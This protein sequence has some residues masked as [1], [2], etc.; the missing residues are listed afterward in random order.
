MDGLKQMLW[1]IFC[2]SVRPSTL[3]HHRQQG[4]CCCF[5]EVRNSWMT[6]SSYETKLCKMTSHF[7]LLTRKYF[8]KFFFRVTNSTL[9]NIKL[10]FELLTLSINF[11]FFTFELLNRSWK[12]KS[13]TLS[14]QLE[15]K[16]WKVTLQVTNSKSRN[17]KIHFELLTQRLNFFCF[18]FELLTRSQKTKS[19]TSIY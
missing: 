4:K 12:T 10:N 11:N 16:K 3:K 8:Y 9:L 6:K 18:T 17:K 7:V 14:Y 5:L 2:A 1:N 15:V 19:Y 13:N